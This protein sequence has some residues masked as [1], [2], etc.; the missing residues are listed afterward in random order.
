MTS[1]TQ[2]STVN[3]T[4]P[5][6]S[7]VT[8]SYVLANADGSLANLVGATFEYVVR[9]DPSDTS[10]VPLMKLTATPT[11]AG[12]LS[13]NTGTSTVTVTVNPAGTLTFPPG[14]YAHALWMNPGTATAQV[15]LRGQFITQGVTQP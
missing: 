3:V 2:P 11:S 5:Q 8:A 13:V 7:L 12:S 15:W 4:N 10:V 9:L 14:L 6:G 1:I